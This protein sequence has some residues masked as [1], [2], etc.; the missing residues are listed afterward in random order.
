MEHT[1]QPIAVVRRRRTRTEVLELITRF[2]QSGQS[3]REFCR[4]H[5]L[6]KSTM[7][8]MIK[9]YQP[10]RTQR[11]SFPSLSQPHVGNTSTSFVPVDIVPADSQPSS[12]QPSLVVELPRG[13]R[14]LLDRNFDVIT[15]E[16]L[17][18]VVSEA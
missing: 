4:Q 1:N 8:N 2:E 9:R 14:V 12:F 17:L 5:N 3:L 16:R 10:V 18:S 6:S 13:L 11:E 15:F 7:S